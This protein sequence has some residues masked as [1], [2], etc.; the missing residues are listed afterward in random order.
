MMQI[1][2][3]HESVFPK[4]LSWFLSTNPQIVIVRYM[5]IATYVIWFIS[6]EHL[7]IDKFH[8]TAFLIIRKY[9]IA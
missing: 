5:S 2:C 4:T 8:T 3:M 6:F 1:N 9:R 7:H